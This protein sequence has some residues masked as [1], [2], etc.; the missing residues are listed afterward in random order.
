MLE[1]EIR[2]QIEHFLEDR[3]D[4]FLI[5]YQLSPTN[6]VE[7]V[8]DGDNGV[9]IQ[10]CVN[11]N[12]QIEN[13]V[14][15]E[16]E[17]YAL[18]VSSYGLSQPLI[19]PR[20]YEKNINRKIEIHANDGKKYNGTLVKADENEVELQWKARV[21]KEIGKGKTTKTFN[22]IIEYKDISQAKVVLTFN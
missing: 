14:D 7:V 12:R 17:D 3:P 2:K 19:N 8:I 6:D 10:D 4:L 15:R 22:Q 11:L 9:K 21:P 20:Q 18:K 16:K 5:K 1:Q 13:N